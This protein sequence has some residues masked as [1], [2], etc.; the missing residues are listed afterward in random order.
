MQIRPT[1]KT[2]ILFISLFIGINSFGIRFRH[3]MFDKWLDENRTLDFVMEHLNDALFD[4][5]L[6]K[7]RTREIVDCYNREYQKSINAR[8]KLW[9]RIIS[10]YN[11][12]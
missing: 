9:S 1:M 12:S 11:L 6:S 5:E 4:P 7:N 3:A 8:S 2:L 10:N